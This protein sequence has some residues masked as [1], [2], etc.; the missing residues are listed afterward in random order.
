VNNFEEF[1]GTPLATFNLYRVWDG[2]VRRLAYLG[3]GTIFF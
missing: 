1:C 3:W 2:E